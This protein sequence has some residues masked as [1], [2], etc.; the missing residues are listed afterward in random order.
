MTH[1][2]S[3]LFFFN[4][5][6]FFS[7][8]P[9][10]VSTIM[11]IIFVFLVLIETHQRDGTTTK[12]NHDFRV[13]PKFYKTFDCKKNR[14]L[15]FYDTN[16]IKYVLFLFLRHNLYF[17]FFFLQTSHSNGNKAQL[18]T[19]R[20][21]L[22]LNWTVAVVGVYE[23][24]EEEGYDFGRLTCVMMAGPLYAYYFVI[25]WKQG[26]REKEGARERVRV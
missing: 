11:I 12:K 15:S 26:E 13:T 3:I 6:E 17:N 10:R 4:E 1:F 14:S 22:Y 9:D 20:T 5:F 24:D 7:V 2:L 23:I 8:P 25:S 21:D 16:T 19:L 18:W